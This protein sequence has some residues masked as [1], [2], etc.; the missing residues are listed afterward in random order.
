MGAFQLSFR[1]KISFVKKNLKHRTFALYVCFLKIK[2]G[3]N[4]YNLSLYIYM[5]V[6][7]HRKGGEGGG[8]PL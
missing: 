8:V 5:A 3:K 2:N 6:N 7:T 1:N 4:A